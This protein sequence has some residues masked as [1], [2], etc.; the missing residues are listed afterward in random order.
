MGYTTPMQQLYHPHILALFFWLT[1][2]CWLG[3]EVWLELSHKPNL[4]TKVGQYSDALLVFAVGTGI[5]A[6]L[7]FKGGLPSAGIYNNVTFFWLALGLAWSGV[8]LRLIAA[9]VLG[10]YH[11]MT[12][13]TQDKQ[14]VISSGPYRYIRH[15]SYLGSLM[16]ITGVA[17]ALNSMLGSI[18]M[19]VL[20]MAAY[21]YRIKVEETYLEKNLGKTYK[22]YKKNTKRLIPFIW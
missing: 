11:V 21:L 16:T 20:A 19:T 8:V 9:K 5:V 6:A 7:V 4:R 18:I 1:C 13:T 22:L 12:I 3:I 15:P 17:I 14:P 2:Y 10:K